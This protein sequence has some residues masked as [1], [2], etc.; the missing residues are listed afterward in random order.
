MSYHIDVLPGDINKDTPH[1]YKN[2]VIKTKI[3]FTQKYSYHTTAIASCALSSNKRL[4]LP[5]I[6][7]LVDNIKKDGTYKHNFVFPFYDNFPKPWVGGLSQGLAISALVQANKVE[8]AEKA[9][10]GLQDNC[11]HVDGLGNTWIEEYPL[12]KPVKILNGFIYALFG[13]Y[14]LYKKTGNEEAE[15]LWKKG[16]RTLK[17]NLKRYDLRNWSKYDLYSEIPAT[18]FYNKIHVKQLAALYNM[19][20][21]KIFKRYSIKWD[22]TNCPLNIRINRIK[23][24]VKKNGT[25]GCWNKHRQ[26][27]RWLDG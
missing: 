25:L 23:K 24:I 3:P 4:A 21:D 1:I 18:P 16:I 20:T 14:D 17:Q 9:F 11:I 5:H 10:N 22:T 13:V 12:D 15:E 6:K 26:R 27:K 2:G 19:T 8:V 7:W